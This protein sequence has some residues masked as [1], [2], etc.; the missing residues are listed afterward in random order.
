[1]LKIITHTVTSTNQQLTISVTC[2]AFIITIISLIYYYHLKNITSVNIN[3]VN[4]NVFT[5]FRQIL[6][7]F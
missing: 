2:H 4:I 6:L 3:T 7:C 1:M 5:H